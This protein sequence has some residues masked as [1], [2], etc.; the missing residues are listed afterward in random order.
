MKKWTMLRPGYVLK[1]RVLFCVLFFFSIVFLFGKPAIA[2]PVL[3][4]Q[5]NQTYSILKIIFGLYAAGDDTTGDDS[6]LQSIVLDT[7][8]TWEN[9]SQLSPSATWPHQDVHQ[10]PCPDSPDMTFSYSTTTSYTKSYSTTTSTTVTSSLSS[11]FSGIGSSLEA[12]YT[13]GYTVG[14]ATNHSS[15]STIEFGPFKVEAGGRYDFYLRDYWVTYSG[16]YSWFEDTTGFG[17]VYHDDPW[18]V[19]ALY[20]SDFIPVETAGTPCPP[21]PEPSTML[22]LS[23]GLAGISLVRLRRKQGGGLKRQS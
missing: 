4:V 9:V 21:V 16:I 13:V 14:T 11:E 22:L 20:K 2:T 23:T 18:S 8:K 5:N 10:Y 3:G 12:S 1:S 7:V 19:T 15:T 17:G 6:E